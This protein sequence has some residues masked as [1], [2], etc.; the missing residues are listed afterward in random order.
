MNY[1]LNIFFP[2]L[3]ILILYILSKFFK[4]KTFKIILTGLFFICA[5]ITFPIV[6][7][8]LRANVWI[9][10][11]LVTPIF[12]TGLAIGVLLIVNKK[13]YKMTLVLVGIIALLIN[14]SI[15][16]IFSFSVGWGGGDFNKEFKNKPIL[17]QGDLEIF[18]HKQ[19]EEL[20]HYMLN[21]TYLDG[22]VYR[23][24]GFETRDNSIC[25]ITFK[26]RDTKEIY[27][28]DK[29]NLFLNRVE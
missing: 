23:Q 21:R 29:C 17:I 10:E 6:L 15:N 25:E 9:Y 16:L 5:I 1:Y 28:F 12:I 4:F 2:L 18:Q 3:I 24:V 22:L 8:D 20:S 27:E 11:Y 19:S 13:Y 14:F 26:L 7:T